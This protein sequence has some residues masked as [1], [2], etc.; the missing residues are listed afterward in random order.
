LTIT[1]ASTREALSSP[2]TADS[3]E[4]AWEL[5]DE[6]LRSI[7]QSSVPVVADALEKRPCPVPGRTVEGVDAA[8]PEVSPT[9]TPAPAAA[10]ERPACHGLAVVGLLAFAL[11]RRG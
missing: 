10:E 1:F 7:L 8:E 6:T 4:E 5:R 11:R 9:S 2:S 3:R